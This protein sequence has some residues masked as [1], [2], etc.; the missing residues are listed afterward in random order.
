MESKDMTTKIIRAHDTIEG[1]DYHE[2][3][4]VST[5]GPQTWHLMAGR[6]LV[7]ECNNPDCTG[8]ALISE[9]AVLALLDPSNAMVLS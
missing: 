8:Q 3:V 5:A 6:W 2:W 9:T 7:A 4:L 1:T